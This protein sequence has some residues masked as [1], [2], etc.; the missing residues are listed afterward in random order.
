LSRVRRAVAG[1]CA[2]G[3]ATGWN[4]AN[5][6]AVAQSLADAYGVGLATVGL[7]TTALFLTHLALQIPGGKASERFGP[8]RVGLAGLVVIACASAVALA[9]HETALTLATRALT[10]VGT[11]LAFIAGS[12]YVRSQGGSPFAQGLFGG[13]GLAGGG[14][15]LATVPVVEGWIGWRAPFAT[16]LGVAVGGIA[17]IAASPRD[18]PRGQE[19]VQRSRGA[20]VLRDRRLY[21]LAALYAASLGLSIVVGNWIVTLLHR[22]GGLDKGSAGAIGALTL[23]LGIVTRP[24]GGWILHT[25]PRRTRA[26][27]GLSLLA[28]AAGTGLLAAA[29]PVPLAVLGAALVGLA[30]GIP[31]SPAFTGAARTRPDA[32]GAAVGFVNGA[33]SA[34]AIVGTPLLGLTFSL[35]GGGRTGFV[36]IAALWLVALALL[37]GPARLGVVSQGD[38]PLAPTAAP[39]TATRSP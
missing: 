1:G 3:L 7:F 4:T 19:P 23:V 34:V 18:V 13:V 12:A 37:P 15:A 10:G 39:T 26:A 38:A 2:L 33:A 30:A 24:L 36:A 25:R 8:R 32:A 28:G 14:V 35:P 17:L 29:K 20:G 5:T 11:G 16:S 6:G 9:A 21:P 27:V 22:Q 31:F